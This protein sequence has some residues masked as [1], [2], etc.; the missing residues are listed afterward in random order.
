MESNSECKKDED[1]ELLD[2]YSGHIHVKTCDQDISRPEEIDFIDSLPRKT[3]STD[4][5]VAVLDAAAVD[6]P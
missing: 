2:A 6:A 1:E 3:T 4:P 5:F